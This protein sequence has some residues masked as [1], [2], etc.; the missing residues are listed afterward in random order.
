MFS[1]DLSSPGFWNMDVTACESKQ[2]SAAK[3][4]QDKQ[5]K[6]FSVHGRACLGVIKSGATCALTTSLAIARREAMWQSK[7]RF[8]FWHDK[9]SGKPV[10]IAT[11]LRPS[12]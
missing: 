11:G 5:E 3:Q 2:D 6:T 8:S 12:Q 1:H 4:Q 7:R 9:R 10:W